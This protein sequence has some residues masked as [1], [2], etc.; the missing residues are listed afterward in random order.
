MK[1]YLLNSSVSFFVSKMFNLNREN[2]VYLLYEEKFFSLYFFY[3]CY[4]YKENYFF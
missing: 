2:G 4:L 1:N 3:K